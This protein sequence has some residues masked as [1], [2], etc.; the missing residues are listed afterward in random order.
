M[1]IYKN[2]NLTTSRQDIKKCK[3]DKLKIR[4]T[5]FGSSSVECSHFKL[6]NIKFKL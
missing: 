4:F 1:K 5:L 2:T 3:C 6:S